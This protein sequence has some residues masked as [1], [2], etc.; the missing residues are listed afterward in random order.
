MTSA[1][2]ITRTLRSQSRDGNILSQVL[3]EAWDCGTLGT[4][5]RASP[6]RATDAHI[7]IIGHAVRDE[8]VSAMSSNEIAG[9]TANR[10]LFLVV[11]RS[12][13][14][15]HGGNLTDGDLRGL[16]ERTEHAVDAA[17][18]GRTVLL[19]AHRLATLGLCDWIVVLEQG[20]VAE[21]GPHD[22]LVAWNDRYARLI[23]T[24]VLRR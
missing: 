16:Q 1:A 6:L 11:R 19:I 2:S 23:A 10:I 14:L 24:G 4:A 7:S 17:R 3:R 13:R 8:L 12:K 9:G 20:R 22:R 15:P 21:E 5:T 18:R